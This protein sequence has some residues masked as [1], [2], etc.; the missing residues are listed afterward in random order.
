MVLLNVKKGE[1]KN[2]KAKEYLRKETSAIA[3]VL[4]SKPAIIILNLIV[5]RK[6]HTIQIASLTHPINP[7]LHTNLVTETMQLASKSAK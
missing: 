4:P 7:L 5:R 2:E 1:S 6:T 3:D